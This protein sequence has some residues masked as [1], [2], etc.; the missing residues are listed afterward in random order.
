MFKDFQ[1]AAIAKVGKKYQTFYIPLQQKLQLQLSESW[2]EQYNSFVE[3][4]DEIYFDSGY[5]PEQHE[6][7]KLD[8]YK[9]PEPLSNANRQSLSDLDSIQIHEEQLAAIKGVAGFVQTE[10][11]EEL[12]L[13]QNFS[14]SHV[15]YPGTFLFFKDEMYQS[16]Q[17][18]GLTLRNK[19]SAIYVPAA[20][21]LLF[22][23]FRLANSFLP[24]AD[25]Y[26]DASEQTI[27]EILKHEKLFAEDADALAIDANQWFRKRFALLRDS[28]IL[29][30]YTSRQIADHA[31]GYGVD[32]QLQNE[33]IVFP[34]EKS[35]AKRLLQ[36]LNEELYKGAITN[37]VYETNSKRQA[38]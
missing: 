36:F 2:F 33:K 32:I 18:P 30:Q 11:D 6:C 15:I 5:Q 14:R 35:S 20:S 27:R 1:L 37:I 23:N 16:L 38:D 25:Y 9:L 34:A 3:G 29:D 10:K 28:E 7:F 31:D 13:F 24:L 26:Q 22:R 17:K 19:L 8:G 4:I 21:K 12:V